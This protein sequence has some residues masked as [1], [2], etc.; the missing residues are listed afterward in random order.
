MRKVFSFKE[1]RE[2]IRYRIEAADEKGYKGRLAEAAGCKGS[3]L[4]QVLND[5]VHLTPE[6]AFGI[7]AFWGLSPSETEFFLLLVHQERAGS[8]ALRQYYA[9]KIRSLKQDALD[10]AKTVQKDS[11][12]FSDPALT[13]LYF[14]NWHIAAIHLLIGIPGYQESPAI[15]KRLQLSEKSVSEALH[16]LAKLNLAERRD[17]K[18]RPLQND[19]HVPKDSPLANLAHMHWRQRAMA[20]Q[21]KEEGILLQFSALNSVALSDLPRLRETLYDAIAAYRAIAQPSA[22]EELICLN[23]DFFK[24]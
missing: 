20:A 8:R 12:S 6:H 10:V 2:L 7:A 4:S 1:Y 16:L 9:D 21:Q 24:V 15:E 13:T 11:Q 18:W 5:T 19:I 14:A 22:E 23:I 3:Y 17:G